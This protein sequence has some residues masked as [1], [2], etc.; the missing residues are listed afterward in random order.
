MILV[1]GATGFLGK[2]LVIELRNRNYPV[3]A[4]VRDV[5]R[6][7]A[8]ANLGVELVKGDITDKTSV[9]KAMDGC[10][11]VFHIAAMVKTWLR[12]RLQFDRVNIE[13]LG[14]ILECAKQCKIEKVIYT[15]SFMALGPTDGT[16]ADEDYVLYPRKFYNDYERTKYLADQLARRYSI[17]EGAQVILYPGVIYG[18]GELTQG[19]IVVSLIQQYLHRKLP[20]M[21][22]DGSKQ[23]NY[24]YIDDVV[25][26]Q[27]LALE[28]AIIGSRYILGGENAS[29]LAFIKLL[30]ELS[31]VP[32]PKW[33]I[34]YWL[35]GLVATGEEL[36]AYLFNRTPQNTHGTI[37]I[38]KHDWTYTSKKA[39]LELG[40]S[41]ISLREGLTKTL[42]WL[43]TI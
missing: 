2:K 33:H 8:I 37:E 17:E 22:G 36:A 40:Y 14:N 5:N 24:V 32:A 1:T 13:G 11:Y 21:L 27:I 43:K 28:R 20:G 7:E 3:R 39:E 26:G 6:A 38:Y 42:D 19:N 23:W 16:I 35:A 29:M 34:P 41:H 12:D 10:Q 9:L 30:E 4:L 31:G 15:S 25:N 18:P